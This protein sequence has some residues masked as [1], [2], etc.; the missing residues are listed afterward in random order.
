MAR[1]SRGPIYPCF[2]LQLVFFFVIKC[3]TIEKE[4]GQ[5]HQETPC[6]ARDEVE[7]YVN[8]RFLPQNFLQDVD[9]RV[10]LDS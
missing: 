5:V 2:F 8:S 3:R 10:P 7:E 4:T 6:M 9:K 1:H